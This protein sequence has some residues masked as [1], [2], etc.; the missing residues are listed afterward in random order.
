MKNY[1]EN[2]VT[3]LENTAGIIL[4][5]G[6]IAAIVQFAGI[7]D[8]N[9][10]DELQSIIRGLK[11]SL[12]IYGL[13]GS[14]VI[15]IL[16][17]VIGSLANNLIAIR[18]HTEKYNQEILRALQNIEGNT[19]LKMGSQGIVDETEDLEVLNTKKF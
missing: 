13:I 3:A 12:G 2:Y 19:K 16:F 1:G 17:M 9:K 4:V 14:G 7:S 6:I 18:V 5:I 8:F 11:I 15:F 10:Y